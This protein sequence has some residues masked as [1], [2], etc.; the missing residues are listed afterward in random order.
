MT[1]IRLTDQP[2]ISTDA[3]GYIIRGTAARAKVASLQGLAH[4]AAT[5]PCGKDNCRPGFVSA[6]RIRMSR[7]QRH[8]DR[9]VGARSAIATSGGYERY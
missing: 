3:K 6:C 8:A 5:W 9:A 4:P 7:R 1:V 2:L